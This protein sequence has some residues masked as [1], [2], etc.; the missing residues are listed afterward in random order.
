MEDSVTGFSRSPRSHP[1]AGDSGSPSPR[2]AAEREADRAARTA[3]DPSARATP[4]TAGEVPHRDHR[5]GGPPGVGRPIEDADRRFFERRFGADLRSV[6]VHD[7]A[8]A[9][10]ATER[11]DS[12]GFT[13]GEHVMLAPDA[14]RAVLAHELVHVLQQRRA[15]VTAL[16]RQ[17]RSPGRATPLAPPSTPFDVV[18]TRPATEDAR[19]LFDHDSTG[20]SSMDLTSLRAV[21][22]GHQP[23]QV[24]VDGYA[25]REGDAEYNVNLSA[26]RAATVAVVLGAML[27]AGSVVRIHAHGAT[28]EFGEDATAN[29]RV[30]IR[31][32]ALPQPQPPSSSQAPGPQQHGGGL[33]L[34]PVQPPLPP[35]KLPDVPDV[36]LREP[37]PYY[38]DPRHPLPTLRDPGL[39]D[40]P[41]HKPPPRTEEPLVNWPAMRQ[42]FVAHG[43][44]AIDPRTAAAIETHTRYWYERFRAMGVPEQ[45]ARNAANLGTQVLVD[46]ELS[47]E[48]LTGPDRV[49]D[50]LRRQGIH[51]TTGGIDL[52]NVLRMLKE[53]R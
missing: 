23:L 44:G 16:Q 25:S 13:V 5:G 15:G 21:L 41:F 12:L 3:L 50:E 17:E 49:N 53:K 24:D 40:S 31:A 45:H 51:T 52:L 1:E 4:R 18:R 26:H 19:V 47:R 9:A 39:A 43:A 27:P 32:T 48:G 7:D 33:R 14:D 46:R 6:R 22:Q 37:V 30:G 20:P 42:S 2:R 34:D 8:A 36:R 38:R 28:T 29:R 11:E 35:G 10:R